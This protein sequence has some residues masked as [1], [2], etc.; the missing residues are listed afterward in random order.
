MTSLSKFYNHPIQKYEYC[1][2]DGNT[3]VAQIARSSCEETSRPWLVNLGTNVWW[4]SFE[5]FAIAENWL[6]TEVK[7]IATLIV[8]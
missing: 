1:D 8:H 4:K 3:Q 5:T 7:P 2:D 6:L